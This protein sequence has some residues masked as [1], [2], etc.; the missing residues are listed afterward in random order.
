MR[1]IPLTA[2]AL[3]I[4]MLLTSTQGALAAGTT[5]TTN[6]ASSKQTK[7]VVHTLANLSPIKIGNKST[8][9]LTD[10]NILTQDEENILTYTLTVA[11]GEG[12]ALD[13]LDY[14]S[15]VKTASGTT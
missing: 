15:K 13:L 2:A 9:R 11:N 1:K 3:G 5:S 12:K 10:V 7:A 8:V 14:W 4:T 6:K